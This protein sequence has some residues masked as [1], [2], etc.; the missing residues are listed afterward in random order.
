MLSSV[1]RVSARM[2]ELLVS[3][4][5]CPILSVVDVLT[6]ATVPLGIVFPSTKAQVS[7]I[8]SVYHKAGLSFDQTAYVEC[9]GTGTRAGDFVELSAVAATLAANR[10]Q[11][12]PIIVGS[13][14]PNIGHLE[15]A[16]GVAG[17][18]KS[19]LVLEKGVIPPQA[20]FMTGN[21]RVDFQEFRLKVSRNLHQTW[22]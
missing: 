16:A 1:V 18:I 5:L 3:S 22:Y 17:L 8:T 20:N 9:H 4:E 13:V 2:A 15:G 21:P 14:K 10:P 6:D 7:N 12:S 11:D 19:V